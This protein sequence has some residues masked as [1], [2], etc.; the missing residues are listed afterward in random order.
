MAKKRSFDPDALEKAGQDVAKKHQVRENVSP[1]PTPKP[2]KEVM[3]TKMIRISQ[4][5]HKRIKLAALQQ[6]MSIQALVEKLID[7]NFPEG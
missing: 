5:Y 7:D 2:Q 1:T 6:D 3:K 4:P